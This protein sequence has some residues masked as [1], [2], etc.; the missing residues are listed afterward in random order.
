LSDLEF[1]GCEFDAVAFRRNVFRNVHLV[2][3]TVT[4][5]DF[6]DNAY[7]NS[8]N[9]LDLASDKIDQESRHNYLADL[10]KWSE[11]GQP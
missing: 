10:Q 5:C 11:R 2:D 7:P 4:R 1:R 3:C 6:R 8:P 9:L